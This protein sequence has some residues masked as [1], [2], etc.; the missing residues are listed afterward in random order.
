[1]ISRLSPHLSPWWLWALLALPALSMAW[2]LAAS[3]SPRIYHILVHPSGEWSVRFLLVTLMATPLAMLFRHARV[4]RWLVRNRRY[5]G[6][7]SFAYAAL[8][9]IFY[10]VDRG[11][12]DRVL[13]QATRFDIATGWLAF[14]VFL[15]LAAT[16]MDYA[17]RKL[18]RRW[19]TVQ[20]W[21]YAAAILTFLHWAGL[22]NWNDPTEAVLYFAPL[23]ALSAYRLWLSG[24]HPPGT[25]PTPTAKKEQ[26]TAG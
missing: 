6:V 13:N 22:H 7:A 3:N 2:N 1:M 9:T 12:L 18:G 8:H 26:A 4:T 11:T 19:K 14:F 17:M 21:V 24:H 10:V 15:P 20:R 5:F 25:G 23:A 16:S